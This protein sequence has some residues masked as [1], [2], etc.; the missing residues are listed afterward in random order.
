[1]GNQTSTKEQIVL[2]V[3][4]DALPQMGIAV[5]HHS[6]RALLCW[7]KAHGFLVDTETAFSLRLGRPLG[8]WLWQEISSRDKNPLE[9][10]VTW[11]NSK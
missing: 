2:S 6:L 8:D 1:M 7:A 10:A 5:S 9:L 3:W 4:K 11:G